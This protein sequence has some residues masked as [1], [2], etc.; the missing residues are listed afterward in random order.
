MIAGL[1]IEHYLT[2]FPDIK[3]FYFAMF[4]PFMRAGDDQREY[5]PIEHFPSHPVF[6]VRVP[7]LLSEVNLCSYLEEKFHDYKEKIRKKKGGMC[8]YVGYIDEESFGFVSK[9]KLK[10]GKMLWLKL[11]DFNRS[12]SPRNLKR[13]E[14][15]LK[16]LKTGPGLIIDSGNSYHFYGEVIFQDYTDWRKFY[17]GGRGDYLLDYRMAITLWPQSAIRVIGRNW[18]RL[19]LKQGFGMLRVNQCSVKPLDPK[20]EKYF[21]GGELG[22]R[23]L[24]G[25]PCMD[26]FRKVLQKAVQMRDLIQTDIERQK[27]IDSWP[28]FKESRYCQLPCN[29]QGKFLSCPTAT[30]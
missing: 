2:W 23:P 11:I 12:I 30:H 15:A 10:N 27:I 5:E 3:S 19:T 1:I 21:L 26:K 18:P 20:L 28:Y 22:V 16:L 4:K 17:R 25:A 9:V 6:E 7:K 13:V 29:F 8:A 14:L 24:P